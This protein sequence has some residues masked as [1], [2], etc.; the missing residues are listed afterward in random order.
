MNFLTGFS[1][2][3]A[4]YGGLIIALLAGFGWYTYHE[5]AIGAAHQLAAVKRAS[6]K[7]EKAANEKIAKQTAQYTVQKN[8]VVISYEQKL[9]LAR[10]Q[11][12]SDR[13]KLE[14]LLNS[15]AR[16]CSSNELL[17]GP[18]GAPTAGSPVQ[19]G[20][21]GSSALPRA[22]GSDAL[23]LAKAVRVLNASLNACEAERNSLTGK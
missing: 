14:R 11:H 4:I 6:L 1:L 7:A 10:A 18:S 2:K 22:L 15:N 5:R 17:R 9:N 23:G 8:K 12:S 16:S 20:T 21:Q 3:D 13:T 19:E